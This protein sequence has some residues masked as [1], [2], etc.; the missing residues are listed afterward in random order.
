M[1]SKIITLI[2]ILCSLF[3]LAAC[4]KAEETTI[5]GMVVSVEGTVVSLQQ[6]DETMKNRKMPEG[7]FPEDFNPEDFKGEMPQ[8]PEGNFP[9]DFNPEDFKGEMPQMP[10]GNFPGDFNPEDF[11]GNMFSQ[12]ATKYDIANAHISIEIEGGKATG[13]M[14][15]IKTGSFLTITTNKK[16]EVTHVIVSSNEISPRSTKSQENS[17]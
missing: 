17:I 5:T 4:G 13:S 6:F 8:M 15:D 3:S 10:E 1:K 11:K 7:N 2:C 14:E 9:E 16:G 12:E